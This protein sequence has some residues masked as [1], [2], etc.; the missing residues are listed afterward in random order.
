MKVKAKVS[1]C[2]RL[3]MYAGEVKDIAP[4]E[5]LADLLRAG[6]VEEIEPVEVKKT[7]KKKVRA[8]EN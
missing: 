4:G 2:G 6:Y 3:S 5:T 8:V 1:F 7:T